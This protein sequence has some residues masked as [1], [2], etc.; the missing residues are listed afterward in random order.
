MTG[1]YAAKHFGVTAKRD[2]YAAARVTTL[3]LP[4]P[5]RLT[6]GVRNPI[7]AWLDELG[8]F[9][10]RSYEKFVPAKVFGLPNDQV[11]LFLAHLWATDG[12]VLWDAKQRQGRIYYGSTS[13]RLIDDVRQLLL[14]LGI[15]AKSHAGRKAGY[16]DCWQLSINGVTNQVRFLTS[17]AI[18]GGKYFSS[19]E[20][21]KNL[22]DIKANE[23][24]DTVPQEVWDQVRRDLKDQ[25]M[26][27]RAF[28]AAMRIKFCGSTLWK[29]SPS[30]TRLK[31]RTVNRLSDSYD[32]D[33]YSFYRTLPSYI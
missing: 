8:L 16:R 9:G 19:R 1:H 22:R 13:R 18:N 20:I 6:H 7:A 5:Y 2:D 4:A 27:H 21:L 26:S 3:R 33:H 17:V 11:A 31:M 15:R 28:S 32:P 30:R 23:N 25:Q 10:K 24:V 29:H 12:C 14:R